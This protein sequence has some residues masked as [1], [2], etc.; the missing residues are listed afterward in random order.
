MPHIQQLD[1]H[2]ADLIAAGEVVERPA[3]VVKELVENAI[4]AGAETVTV[5]IQR[6]GM[7]LIRV[8]DNGCGI[9]ADEAETAFLRHATSK[10]RTEH[11][12]EAIGTLGFRGEALAAIAAVSRVELL[13]RT[14]EED[15][16]AALSLEGGEVVSREE[17]GCPV[18]TT[19]VVRD[20]FFNTPA[21]LK[22]MKKDA[23]EGAAVFAMVQRLALAHPEVSMKFLRDG[24]QELL[25]PGDGQMKS[26]VYS[27]LGRDLALGLIEVK[28]SGE[29]MTVTGFTS[30][31][32]CC[33]PTRG[34]QHFFVNGRYVKSRTMMAAL[35]EAYQNQKMVGKFPACV[36]YLTCRLSSVDVNVHPTKQEVK[37]GNERQ[38]FSAVYYAVLSALEGDKSHVQA[39][40]GRPAGRLAPTAGHDTVTPNQTTFRTMTAQEYRKSA[41]G[42]KSGLP[43]HDFAAPKAAA[44]AAPVSRPKPETRTAESRPIFQAPVREIPRTVPEKPAVSVEKP[45]ETVI[46]APEKTPAPIPEEKVI[47]P[48][49]VELPEEKPVSPVQE[50]P[51]PEVQPEPE[52]VPVQPREEEIPWRVAGE[53]LNTYIIVE[54]GDKVL[55]IDKH[56]AHERMNFDRLKAQGYQ[57]MVQNL[58]TPAVFTPPAEEGAVL[59]QNLPL[60]AQFGFDAEDFG[61]GAIIVRAAPGDV[62]AE[63]VPATLEEIAA[64]L[65]TTGRANPDAARDEL[66]H[67][68]A[69]KAAIKGGQKNGPQELEKVAGAVMRGEV[70]YCPH[71]RPVAIEMTRGQLEKQFKRA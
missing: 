32:A 2:V 43:L 44:P 51:A 53:V 13:T 67:T 64:K 34:Y 39:Q 18:G 36:L 65:L 4:D 27:V 7:S 26:A 59:L 8:T 10:I 3:S 37:F 56:A 66:M 16:G 52:S 46:P 54:Q 24:K 1:P 31:P 70:K 9:A 21:R 68:M 28:G 41:A 12:L 40:V 49:P 5:E 22:F 6:G 23:A 62:D 71:G 17:A 19:M 55:L 14:A 63:D 30:L 45:A 33:R 50:V 38:V 25:T 20:L 48:E 35:E 69:C 11:D 15:L 58:L 57:P 47:F 61:G 42:T 29:D 60:L